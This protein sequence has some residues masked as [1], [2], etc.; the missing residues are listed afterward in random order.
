VKQAVLDFKCPFNNKYKNT[1]SL[2]IPDCINSL[3]A[4]TKFADK[5]LGMGGKKWE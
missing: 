2:R 3:F 1:V 4:T 5:S